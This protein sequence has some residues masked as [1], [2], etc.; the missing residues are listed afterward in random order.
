LRTWFAIAIVCALTAHAAADDDPASRALL[1]AGEAQKLA[2]GGDYLGAAARYKS[3]LALDP[4]PEY[5][6]NVGIAYW[7]ARDLPRAQ[8]FLDV[9]SAR[10][11][12]LDEAFVKSVR[13]VLDAVEQKLREGDFAPVNVTVDPP[14]AQ[15]A[16]SS[17]APDD[18]FVGSRT[19]WLPFGTH[20]LIATAPGHDDARTTVEVQAHT[21][22]DAKLVLPETPP[23][24]PRV[25][26]T[27]P[28][29]VVERT[30][31]SR[32]PAYIGA[33]ATVAALITDAILYKSAKDTADHAGT[34][35]PGTDYNNAQSLAVARRNQLYAMYAVTVGAAAVT[36][37]L[38]WRARPITKHVSVT[39]E[40]GGASLAFTT[41][42]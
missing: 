35:P 21:A 25:I 5:Q 32:I 24:P 20:E 4:R 29:I 8:L 19:I 10:A 17:F 34:L 6:C 27:P 2:E 33:G 16:V 3:A 1:L 40:Q 11:S 13:D 37:Y 42:F 7:K 36:G 9:C 31:P 18:T 15:V 12:H 14:G 41:A 28:K 22:L 30:A 23:P 38:F 39:P 26:H